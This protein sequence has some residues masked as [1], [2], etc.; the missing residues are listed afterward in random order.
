MTDENDLVIRDSDNVRQVT[1]NRPKAMNSLRLATLWQ[2]REVLRSIPAELD[3]P[4]GCRALVITGAGERAFCAGADIKELQVIGAER[5]AEQATLGQEVFTEIES[6]P[7]VTIAA[8]NGYALGGG[9]ELA[10]A[11]DFRIASADAQLGQPEVGL[12]TIPGWGGTVRLPRLIGAPAAKELIF[13]SERIGAARAYELGLVDRVV[14]AA[15][16]LTAADEFATRFT[17]RSPRAIA[18]A[19]AAIHAGLTQGSDGLQAEA[20]FVAEAAAQGGNEGIA[21]FGRGAN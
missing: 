1:I 12:G 19:K 9:L 16:L 4:D 6:A 2:L 14:E 11:C 8:I 7:V 13:S 15:D 18:R 17:P 5:A 21:A 3:R 10:L 20:R